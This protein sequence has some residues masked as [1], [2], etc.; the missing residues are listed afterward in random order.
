MSAV[1]YLSDPVGETLAVD[2]PRARVPP[3]PSIGIPS[4]I[5]EVVL[6]GQLAF[7]HRRQAQEFLVRERLEVREADAVVGLDGLPTHIGHAVGHHPSPPEVLSPDPVATLPE[8][9]HDERRTDLLAWVKHEVGLLLPRHHPYA[10]AIL[11]Q[12]VRRPLSWPAESD[13]D[14]R[15]RP[16]EVEVAEIAVRRPPAGGAD[17]LVD[18]RSQRRLEGLIVVRLAGAAHIVVQNESILD[19]RSE[20]GIEPLQA[21]DERRVRRAGVPQGD[22]P[23]DHREV[24]IGDAHAPHLEPSAGVRVGACPAG[25]ALADGLGSLG[26]LPAGQQFVGMSTAVGEHEGRRLADPSGRHGVPE[27]QVTQTDR[28]TVLERDGRFCPNRMVAGD[29]VSCV[30]GGEGERPSAVEFQ[31]DRRH[32]VP[33]SDHT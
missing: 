7:R 30:A 32:G 6:D 22:R 9:E 24:S 27:W 29:P 14:A 12:E 11:P 13:D 1:H 10:S 2:L 28:C 18:H 21:L 25:S 19:A 17:P 5:Q 16:F 4:R 8:E 26:E 3:T 31:G 23:L 15:P 20:A 33:M